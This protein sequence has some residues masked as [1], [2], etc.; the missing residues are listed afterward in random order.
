MCN[1]NYKNEKSNKK[2]SFSILAIPFNF[3]YIQKYSNNYGKIYSKY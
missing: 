1:Y 3:P 2:E